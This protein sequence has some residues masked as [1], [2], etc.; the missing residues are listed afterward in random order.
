MSCGWPSLFRFCICAALLTGL[1][2]QPVIGAESYLP[3]TNP[4]YKVIFGVY[5]RV[6]RA[7]ADQRRPPRLLVSAK[8]L[9]RPVTIEG[10][11]VLP[12][13]YAPLSA[14]SR[15]EPVI[16]VDQRLLEAV[17]PLGPNRD[18]AL[19]LILG[20]DLAHFYLRHRLGREGLGF[21][22]H[23]RSSSGDGPPAGTD[24]ALRERVRTVATVETEA[25]AD[26]YGGFYGYLAGYDTIGVADQ[27]FD[28]VYRRL[29][30]TDLRGYPS[31][32]DRKQI[33]ADVGRRL[34]ELSIQ[35]ETANRLLVVGRPLEAARLLDRLATQVGAVEIYT[36]AGVA[37]AVA[38]LAAAPP[39]R[40]PYLYPFMHDRESRLASAGV[41]LPSDQPH[42]TV[43]KHSS[44]GSA[45]S[46]LWAE[47]LQNAARDL[48]K[49]LALNPG[50][51]L[52]L[53]NRAAVCQIAGETETA[54]LLARRAELA[55]DDELTILSTVHVLRGI[56]QAVQGGS[57]AAAR[58]FRQA[59]LQGSRQADRNLGILLTKSVE[60]PPRI[61]PQTGGP[62]VVDGTTLPAA[63]FILAK[64][65]L[66]LTLREA[67]GE[68]V[69]I[70]R[71]SYPASARWTVSFLDR[72]RTERLMVAFH[73]TA[74]GYAGT[75]QG[76]R[77]GSSTADLRRIFGSPT[78]LTPSRQ[79]EYWLYEPD[80][81]VFSLNKEGLVE[82]WIIF[83]IYE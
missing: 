35:Y 12:D 3:T 23:F 51:P 73:V 19:A 74:P 11:A 38:A 81:V 76:L 70:A 63:R 36:N 20:H 43:A 50:N 22:D 68:A 82:G 79:G 33:M 29:N 4:T 26:Y 25:E 42:T 17:A 24:A 78:Q 55:A 18:S 10:G 41:A 71:Q 53:V 21:A 16:I 45:E 64:P 61:T 75:V 47:Y 34:G 83:G 54:L 28:L 13:R 31:L 1:F 27:V 39:G 69:V 40:F 52:A 77:I 58:E 32:A 14:I 66:T 8:P 15:E 72:D 57:E 59:A 62:L 2:P 30:V 48:D 49:A 5:D 37:W 44:T 46:E 60:P 7:F 9:S 80:R 56:I 65:D 67:D 6:A